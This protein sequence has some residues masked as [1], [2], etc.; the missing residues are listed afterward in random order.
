MFFNELQQIKAVGE[1]VSI[2]RNRDD[3]NKFASGYVVGVNERFYILALISPNGD[4]D[5]FRLKETE[6]IYQ[7]VR[8]GPDEQRMS[9]LGDIKKVKINESF[10]NDDLVKELLEFALKRQKIV[11]IELFASDYDDCI[12]LVKS[13]DDG[14]CRTQLINKYGEPDGIS[15]VKLSDIT[16]IDCDYDYDRGLKI[17]YESRG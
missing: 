11:T 3:T 16:T 1:L 10:E 2:Y 8:G 4:Y 13:V 17:L 12:G 14:L 6:V 15:L 7:I 5:G 9:K